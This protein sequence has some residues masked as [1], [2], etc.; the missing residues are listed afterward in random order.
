ME[1][2]IGVYFTNAA[3]AEEI[4]PEDVEGL[5]KD[6]IEELQRQLVRS[7]TFLIRLKE[8]R[9]TKEDGFLD[10]SASLAKGYDQVG[11]SPIEVNEI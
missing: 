7:I 1:S 2:N 11:P 9:L 4:P 6:S 5:V 8:G 10:F 3:T